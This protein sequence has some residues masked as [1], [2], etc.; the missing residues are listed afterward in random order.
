[1]AVD[2]PMAPSLDYAWAGEILPHGAWVCVPFGRKKVL[3]LVIDA[4]Q[5]QKNAAGL[6]EPD[7]QLSPEKIKAVD[8]ALAAFPVADPAWIELMAFA[9]RYYRRPFGTV[10]VGLVPKWLRDLK[11]FVAKKEGG[12]SNFDRLITSFEAKPLQPSST[13]QPSKSS[14]RGPEGRGN[15]PTMDSHGP[16]ALGVNLNSHQLQAL[17]SIQSPGVH[18]LHGVTGSGKTRVYTEA[19]RRVFEQNP[20]AQVL[21]MVPEI[22]L[23]PQLVGRFQE[24]LPTTSIAVLHSEVS[25]RERARLWLSAATGQAQ[26]IIGTRL[27]IM[28]P[29]PNLKLIMIDEEHD[30]SYKQQEGMRY[31]ARDLAVWR[32]QQLGIPLVLGSATPSIETWAQIVRNKYQRHS[33]PHRATG[34]PPA[35]IRLIDT[36]KDPAKEGLSTESKQAIAQVLADGGQVLVFLNRRGYAPVLMCSSCGWSSKCAECSVPTVLHRSVSADCHGPKGPRSDGNKPVIASD[37]K[38]STIADSHGALRLGMTKA[39]QSTKT[40]WRLQ[41]HHCGI[42]ASVPRQ[43]PDCGDT[44]LQPVGRGVQ[45]LEQTLQEEFPSAR[46]LRIDRDS[47]KQGKALQAELARIERGEVDIVV[48]T[49][50]LAKGHDFARMRLVVVADADTQLLNSDFRAPERLFATL[51]QVA[52]RAGRHEQSGTPA[53]VLVQTRYPQH[54]LYR[55]LLAQDV[56]GFAQKEMADRQAAG[57]PPFT[58]MAAI[59]ASHADER[60]AQSALRTLRDELQELAKEQGWAVTVYGPVA[61]YPETQA[62]R[63]RGQ[64]LL[65][66]ASRPQLHQLLGMAEEWMQD[67]RTMDP[68]VD[69]DP[70]EV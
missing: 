46:I 29:L 24:A 32:A 44:D 67:N 66:S 38:Q 13:G 52:G 27:A 59:R 15:P 4:Q 1:V 45:R 18:V 34:E 43:C 33:L 28:T 20:I 47:V 14:L 35:P 56:E 64:L 57:L 41:C 36:L 6:G 51:I 5:F 8:H 53:Q 22:G 25:E 39:R 49:Q 62:G 65:E 60:K 16:S 12:R 26:L 68:H 17:H 54:P 42:F 40:A 19:A 55:F 7:P 50:M 31:S 3:G 30:H 70:V 2:T 37:A 23:T 63:W 61:R 58:F 48:G 9:A 21:I 10:A 11:N 69:V